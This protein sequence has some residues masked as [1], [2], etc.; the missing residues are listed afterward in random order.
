MQSNPLESWHKLVA[1]RDPSALDDILAD[2]V[3]FHSPVVHGAQPGK[4]LTKMYLTAAAHILARD[5]FQYV[6]E[7]ISG[8]DAVLEFVVE[9]DG[10][11]ING[12]DMIRWDEEGK[13]TEFKV[14]LRPIKAINLVHRMMAEMLQKMGQYN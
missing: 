8:N 9:I 1:T 10:V 4:A 7:V 3:V 12:V 6:R 2:E 11:H 14:M 13:I 5:S